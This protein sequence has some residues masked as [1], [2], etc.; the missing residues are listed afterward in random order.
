MIIISGAYKWLYSCNWF[1]RFKD[2]YKK[3]APYSILIRESRFQN[4]TTSRMLMQGNFF[5]VSKDKVKIILW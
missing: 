1:L 4:T 5:H 2:H 3:R